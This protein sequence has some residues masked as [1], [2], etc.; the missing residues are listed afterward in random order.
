MTLAKNEVTEVALTR[1]EISILVSGLES[2][3]FTDRGL[4]AIADD[5][6]ENLTLEFQAMQLR[7]LS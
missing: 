3:I 7:E 1:Q 5:L 2:V 4:Q 6:K